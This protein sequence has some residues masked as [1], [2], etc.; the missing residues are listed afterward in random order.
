MDQQSI[1][2]NYRPDTYWP[3]SENREQRLAHIQGQAR[4]EITRDILNSGGIKELNQIG[5][6]VA[7]DELSETDREAWG[8]LHPQL[9]GGEYLSSQQD[10]KAEIAR[11]SLQSVT[12]DQICVRASTHNGRIHY[13]IVDEYDSEYLLP[14]TQSSEPLTLQEL[15]QILDCTANP[16]SRDEGGLIRCHWYSNAEYMDP[17]EAIDFVSVSSVF[18][19]ELSAYYSNEA[20]E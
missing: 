9:M 6:E 19:P 16:F 1:N 5:A 15:I 18:Y 10:N 3:E 2:M 8:S 4:R 11:I 12:A 13:Q 7:Q 20:D 14:I 17:E